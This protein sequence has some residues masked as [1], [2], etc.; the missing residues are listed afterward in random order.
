MQLQAEVIQYIKDDSANNLILIGKWGFDGRTGQAEYK[1]K[2]TDTDLSHSSFLVTS[3]VPLRL[4]SES[5]QSKIIW[6]NPRPPS[7]RFCRPT[8]LE[9]EI[10]KIKINTHYSSLW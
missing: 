5:D 6:K 8:I 4:I 3:Y 7:T 2:V 1:Q 10:K 9:S